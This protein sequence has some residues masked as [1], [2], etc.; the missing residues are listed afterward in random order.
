MTQPTVPPELRRQVS[1]EAQFRCGYC[2]TSQHG[3]LS[4]MCGC[5]SERSEESL[6]EKCAMLRVHRKRF[7]VLQPGKKQSPVE[8]IG[9]RFD[10][11]WW[12]TL[13]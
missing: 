1:A 9:R 2:H 10:L 5:H 12:E 11:G 13:T 4:I 3:E 6:V 8:I 7:A